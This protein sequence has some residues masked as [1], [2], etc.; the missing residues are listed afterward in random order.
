M[1]PMHRWFIIILVLVP[2]LLS[3]GAG[4]KAKPIVLSFHIEA[5]QEDGVKF[6]IPVKLGSQGRQY[7]FTRAPVFTEK[8]IAYYYPFM[9]KNG[10]TFGVGF[11]LKARAA[12]E[13]KG[14][15]LNHQGKLLGIRVAPTHYSAVMI[16]RP[17]TP[18]VIT[19]WEGLTQEHIKTLDK[20]IPHAEKV[21]RPGGPVR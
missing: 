1:F 6:A 5:A 12:E 14:I 19:I 7:F 17:D 21:I 16:D 13:L 9:S 3:I 2:A 11:K 15:A 4:K 20:V 8:D 18:G 10:T